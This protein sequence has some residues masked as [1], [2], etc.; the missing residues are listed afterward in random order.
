[1]PDQ[2]QGRNLLAGHNT[3]YRAIVSGKEQTAFL[4]SSVVCGLCIPPC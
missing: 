4:V 2:G 1:M 3:F